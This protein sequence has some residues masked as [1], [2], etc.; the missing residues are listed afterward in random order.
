[1][2][3]KSCVM[4]NVEKI[5]VKI[6][7]WVPQGN[8][9]LIEKKQMSIFSRPWTYGQST[10]DTWDQNWVQNRS[11]SVKSHQVEINWKEGVFPPTPSHPTSN[12]GG[13]F[14]TL[15]LINHPVPV[16]WENCF[17][18]LKR[19]IMPSAL[20]WGASGAF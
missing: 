7:I 11:A 14:S 15:P 3:S 16:T 19:N 9:W 6:P 20:S 2:I 17:N 12:A 1:M 10:S 13:I 8:H 4:Q 5:G 18:C